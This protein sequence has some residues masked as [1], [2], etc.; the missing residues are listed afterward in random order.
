MDSQWGSGLNSG[1]TE[2]AHLFVKCAVGAAEKENIS[3]AAIFTDVKQA[4]GST[5]GTII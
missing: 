2:N 3:A 4:N 1:A 5:A